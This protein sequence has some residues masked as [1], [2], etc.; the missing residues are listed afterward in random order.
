MIVKSVYYGEKITSYDADKYINVKSEYNKRNL[1]PTDEDVT[2]LIR[3]MSDFTIKVHTLPEF[4]TISEMEIWQ[5][6]QIKKK[7]GC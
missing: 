6:K 1:P 5:R 7:L 2:N 4:K 3:L